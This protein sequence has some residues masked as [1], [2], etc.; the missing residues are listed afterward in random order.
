MIISSFLIPL[1]VLT[2]LISIISSMEQTNIKSTPKDVFLHLFNIVTF[3][4]SVI[5]FITLYIQ[6]ISAKFPD[7]LNYYFTDIADAVRLFSSILLIAVPAYLLTAWMLAKDLFTNPAKRELRLR[8]WLVYF[9]LFI[10][11]ITIVIDLI[12]FIYNFLSGELTIQFFLK[13]LTVLLVAVAVFAYYLWDLK[14]EDLKSKL[15]KI[16]GIALVLIMLGSVAMGFFIIGSP[17]TQRNRRFDEQRVQNL[18]MIQEQVVN[19][20]QRKNELPKQLTDLQDSISGFNIPKDPD[21]SVKYEYVIT[22]PL[23]FDLC[24]TF[25]TVSQDISN[26]AVSPMGYDVYQQNWK[27]KAERTCFSRTIDPQ[28]HKQVTNPDGTVAQPVYVK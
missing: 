14:R 1:V 10:S 18:Q 27:H 11:A 22:G 6:Y 5:G 16:L 3:Y 24:S 13:I 7:P 2:I 15:P 20:W 9:T 17:T 25:K 28:L 19:Y 4:L 8:K 21:Q 23:A 26:Q 12:T